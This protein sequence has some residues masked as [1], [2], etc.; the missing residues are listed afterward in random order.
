MA[1]TSWAALETAVKDS[2]ADGNV[3]VREFE[4]NDRKIKFRSWAEVWAFLDE[5]EAKAREDSGFT[6]FVTTEPN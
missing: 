2:I 5:V 1:F 6:G 4:M 3:L